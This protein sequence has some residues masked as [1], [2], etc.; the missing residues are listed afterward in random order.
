MQE[1]LLPLH[2]TLICRS[3]LQRFVVPRNTSHAY[4]AYSHWRSGTLGASGCYFLR[5]E[6]EG[7]HYFCLW[8]RLLLSMLPWLIARWTFP[9]FLF[10]DDRTDYK[11]SV[12]VVSSFSCGDGAK[13]GVSGKNYNAISWVRVRNQNGVGD[14]S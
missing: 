4:F 14:K 3:F 5:W 1:Y 10:H 6:A 8:P 11:T 9:R 7:K 13:G 2:T 12:V